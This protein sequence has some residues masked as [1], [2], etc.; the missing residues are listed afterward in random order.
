MIIRPSPEEKV[1]K[2][3]RY[4]DHGTKRL[5]RSRTALVRERLWSLRCLAKSIRFDI[6]QDHFA[7]MAWREQVL[8]QPRKR[9]G[10]APFPRQETG[11]RVGWLSVDR[12]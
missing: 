7:A 12:L 6:F 3:R 10:H 9:G 11:N 5:H 2:S 8:K 4:K 1:E